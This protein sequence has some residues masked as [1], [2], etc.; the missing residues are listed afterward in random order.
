MNNVFWRLTA[1][2]Y[3]SDYRDSYINGSL[4]HPFGL[5]GVKCGSCR[6]TWGGSRILPLEAPPALRGEKLLQDRWPVSTDRHRELQ[7]RVREEFAKQGI[8][9]ERL[10]PGDD[11]QPCY[12]DV[13]SRPR[14]DFLWCSPESV[15]VSERVRG[16]LETLRIADVA[17]CQ[18]TL[19]KVGRREAHLPPPMPPTG[20][21]EDII[22][23]VPLASEADTVGPYW[24]MIVLHESGYPTGGEPVRVCRDC[25][26]ETIDYKRRKLN[27]LP[28]MWRGQ[29][30]FLMATTLYIIVTDALK[31][32]LERIGPT[33][34]LFERC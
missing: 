26:R 14:A 9:V 25:G 23:S 33:N 12:L 8:T 31:R 34:V 29:N 7:S 5:P 21:P 27:M 32:E 24:E 3:D 19:R 4:E 1:P 28:S 15:V 6:S 17:L 20:E 2:D 22:D 10:Y 16:L 11:F 13:P 30:I 18:V